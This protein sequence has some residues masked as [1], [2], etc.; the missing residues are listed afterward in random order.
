MVGV[1]VQLHLGPSQVP[2]CL[3]SGSYHDTEPFTSPDPEA[4]IVNP[5]I[6][7]LDWQ[8][9]ASAPEDHIKNLNS[10][11][12]RPDIIVLHVRPETIES[13]KAAGADYFFSKDS[14]PDQLLMC[15]RKLK[16]DRITKIHSKE[17][18]DETKTRPA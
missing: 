16:Q 6:V 8:L 11:E 5:D 9:V 15:L 17:I 10:V 4:V 14:P 2:Y 13:A 7:L 3:F 1:G 18:S 12:S